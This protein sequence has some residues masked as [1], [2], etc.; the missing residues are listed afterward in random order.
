MQIPGGA[1]GMVMAKIDSC[2]RTPNQVGTKKISKRGW[3][4]LEPF[5]PLGDYY[6]SFR[7]LSDQERFSPVVLI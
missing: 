1:R 7:S 5:E 6:L 3:T 2:V 4:I